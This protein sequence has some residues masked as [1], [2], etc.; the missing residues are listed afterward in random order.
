MCHSCVY[1]VTSLLCR[2]ACCRLSPHLDLLALA[3][4]TH[5]AF[6][7]LYG[8]YQDLGPKFAEASRG[9]GCLT[10]DEFYDLLKSEYPVLGNGPSID[11]LFDAFDADNNGT[12]DFQVL[13][14]TQSRIGRDCMQTYS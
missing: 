7:C 5:C 1:V 12:I 6:A 3:A 8:C 2:V 10:R 14:V 9:R 4:V 11:A 13:R